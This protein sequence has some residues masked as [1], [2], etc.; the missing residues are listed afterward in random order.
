MQ[1]PRIFARRTVVVSSGPS[2]ASARGAR[3]EAGGAGQ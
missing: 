2:A 3:D 1:M